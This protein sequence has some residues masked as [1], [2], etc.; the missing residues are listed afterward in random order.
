M[1]LWLG[2]DQNGF[3]VPKKLHRPG[4]GIAQVIRGGQPDDFLL[5]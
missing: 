2:E 1:S 5:R 3:S 4:L